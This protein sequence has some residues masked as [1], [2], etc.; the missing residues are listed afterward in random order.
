VRISCSVANVTKREEVDNAF[1]AFA[2]KAG[3]VAVL[4]GNAGLGDIDQYVQDHEI[5]T[6]MRNVAV[7][8]KGSLLGTQV[9]IQVAA[10]NAVLVSVASLASF[11]PLM[12]GISAYTVS[13]AAVVTFFGC[14]QVEIL[15]CGLLISNLVWSVLR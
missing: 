3:N 11:M 15:K 7:N 6:W 9:F 2:N 13:K 14:V 5:G 4:V 10:T 8:P 12:G 1:D